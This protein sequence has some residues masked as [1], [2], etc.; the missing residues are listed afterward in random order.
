MQDII[1]KEV[2]Y[3]DINCPVCSS[4]N[5]FQLYKPTLKKNEIPVIGYDFANENQKKHLGIQNVII[6]HIYFLIL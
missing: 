5:F 1:K 4:D 2:E 3:I 6:V